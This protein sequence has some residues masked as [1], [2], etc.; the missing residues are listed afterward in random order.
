M[1]DRAL[2]GGDWGARTAC[3]LLVCVLAGCSQIRLGSA[4]GEASD[5]APGLPLGL[6]WE[7]D[8]DG[9]FGPSGA[10]V[11]DRYVVVGTRA[12]EVVVMER[13]SGRIAGTGEFGESVE[14]AIAVSPDGETIYVPTAETGGGVEAF[15]VRRGRRVWR[16]REGAVQGGVALVGETLVVA[17]L[18]G[19]VV[20]LEAS[21]GEP[22][23]EKASG[24]GVQIHAAPVQIGDDVLVADDHGGVVRVEALTGLRRWEA[25]VGGPVYADPVVAFDGAYVSTTRGE[26]VRLDV[27]T[28]APIWRFETGE[29]V[30]ASTAA[31]G[32]GAV[33]VGFSDGTVRA[34]GLDTGLEAWRFTT[35]GNV[36]APPLWLGGHVAVGTMDQ[37]LVLLEAGTGREVWSTELRGRVKSA[38]AVGGGLLVALVEPRHVVAFHTAP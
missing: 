1:S 3:L 11:T 22:R 36:S 33:A 17:T 19:R 24:E 23:W 31:V 5:D 18:D 30:R 13:E 34:L 29:T 16:W 15:D 7:R 25:R 20:G 32:E 21:T 26:V 6:S 27:E 37:R 10:H 28:G 38:L 2:R 4:L 12:G 8:A 9:A 14:G 35:D